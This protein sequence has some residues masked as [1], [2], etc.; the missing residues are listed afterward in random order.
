[1]GRS[2]IMSRSIMVF[3]IILFFFQICFLVYSFKNEENKFK[4]KYKKV[5]T[6]NI[7]LKMNNIELKNELN[8][9]KTEYENFVKKYFFVNVTLTAYTSS[10][11]ETNND[12]KNTAIMNSPI[13][14]K[15]VAVSRDLKYL[16][17]KKIYIEG[18]GVRYVNDLMN[19]RFKKTVDVLV[20]DVKK[21][22]DFGVKENRKIILITE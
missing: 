8:E 11:R 6:E 17:G 4:E 13:S 16:L 9:I 7:E 22:N 21:A 3:I 20:P 14:G 5:K 2:I 12:P 1:M 18:I 15:T 10:I 19:K